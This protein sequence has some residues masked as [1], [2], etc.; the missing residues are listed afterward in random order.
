MATFKNSSSPPAA[1]RHR[2]LWG[3]RTLDYVSLVGLLLAVGAIVGGMILEGGSLKQIVQPSA[4]I[5]VFGGTAGAVL[6]TTPRRI[7]LNAISKI[8]EVFFE[9]TVHPSALVDQIVDFSTRVRKNG[10]MSLEAD[11]NEMQDPYLRKM[12]ML[13]ID[14]A[15]VRELRTMMELEI[16]LEE[17]LYEESAKVFAA[18]GGYAPTIGIIGAVL[19]LMQVMKNLEN[20]SEVGSGIATAFVATVYG[21]GLANVVLLPA[22]AKIKARMQTVRHLRMLQ[23]RGILSIVE[24][25]NP[26]LIRVKLEAYSNHWRTGDRK[27]SLPGTL[28]VSK[29]A[30][31]AKGEFAA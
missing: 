31:S 1:S 18:A 28:P 21:V 7:L 29:S 27:K 2:S 5:I 17:Q 23:L 22:G 6:L 24:G 12:L 15:E 10:I 8:G 16:S 13:A 14:G 30:A 4:A 3:S 9:D 19:G 26:K 11:M 25:V 20:I